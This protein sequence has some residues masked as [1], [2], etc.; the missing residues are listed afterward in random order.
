M[1]GSPLFIISQISWKKRNGYD[2]DNVYLCDA[3]SNS[4]ARCTTQ[5]QTNDLVHFTD[6]HLPF[7][8]SMF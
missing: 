3:Q 5:L 8:L 7:R 1:K 4:N 6:L 2:R